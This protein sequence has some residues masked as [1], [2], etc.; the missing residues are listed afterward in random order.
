VTLI[1]ALKVLRSAPKDGERF[2]IAIVCGFT[3]VHVQTFLPAHL[4]ALL[5]S[6][7][8][9]PRIGLFGDVAGTLETL[10]QQPAEAAAV[11]LEWGDLDPRL[12]FRE[13]GSWDSEAAVSAAAS[14]KRMLDRLQ[15]AI[16]RLPRGMR[17]VIS[18]PALPLPPMFHTT[19]WQSPEAELALQQAIATFAAS[20]AAV[21]GVLVLSPRTLAGLSPEGARYDFKSDLLTGNPYTLT[22]T[23]AVAGAVARLLVPPPPKKGIITDLDDTLWHGIVGEVGPEKVCWDLASHH[24]LHGLYQKLLAGASR[25]GIL[26][27]IATKNSPETVK[28]A[29]SRDDILLPL[30]RVFPVEVH[31]G[32]KSAS[33]SRI[34]SRWNINADAVVFVDDSPMELAEV[35]AAHPGITCIQ[36]PVGDYTAGHEMLRS[37]RDLIGKERLWA[38]DAIRLQSIRDSAQF[39]E[40]AAASTT[41]EDFLATA[42]ASV[43]FDYRTAGSDGRVLELINKTNQFNLNGVR[44]SESEWG[45]LTGTPGSFVAS[46]AYQDRFAKLGKIAAFAGTRSHDGIDIQVWVMSCRAF[47]RRIEHQCVRNLFE[48]F[49][50]AEIRFRFVSTPRNGPVATFLTDLMGI[51]PEADVKITREQ[52]DR[53]CPALYHSVTDLGEV[54]E[55]NG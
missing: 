6:R 30:D 39:Q 44:Y 26:V 28:A 13:S 49:E 18:L 25:D 21:T 2:E 55:A 45:A 37:L 4:Q 41:P 31:W 43:T 53:A 1:D 10:V 15:A 50:P 54:F 5:P 20:I 36:F 33:I 17:T 27:G 24:H 48:R 38:D 8:V 11:L 40:A 9:T 32:A 47:S 3:P 29:F 51:A 19:R 12:S 22:H 23:D 34:L 14:A 16:E 42:D 35:A 52:F 46:V 7:K